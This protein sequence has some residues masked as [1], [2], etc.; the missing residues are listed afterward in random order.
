MNNNNQGDMDKPPGDLTHRTHSNR[1]RPGVKRKKSFYEDIKGGS[2]RTGRTNL[3]RSCRFCKENKEHTSKNGCGVYQRLKPYLVS[4]D[5]RIQLI[6]Q[7]G[8]FSLHKFSPCTAVIETILRNREQSDSPVMP[9]PMIAG[10]MIL[11]EAYYD[12]SKPS[13][14]T[15][16]GVDVRVGN[17]INNV[18]GVEFIQVSAGQHVDNPITGDRMFYYRVKEVQDLIQ[19]KIAGDRLLFNCL[20]K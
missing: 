17:D 3:P 5:G 20:T 10:H 9:W 7:L 16:Y 6:A 14:S 18:I 19:Q 13:K 8:D 4:K 1:G 15:R 2:V 12:F 11:R